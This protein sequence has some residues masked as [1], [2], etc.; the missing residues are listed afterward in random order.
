MRCNHKIIVRSA[1]LAYGYFK[2]VVAWRQSHGRG[3]TRSIDRLLWLIAFLGTSF[4]MSR[5]TTAQL[6]MTHSNEV[7]ARA[8]LHL[9]AKNNFECARWCPL[10]CT[11]R[12]NCDHQ[13]ARHAVLVSIGS[14]D[15]YAFL[16]RQS[17]R[18]RRG[19][20]CETNA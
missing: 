12:T 8:A 3:S 20:N 10:F 18:E 11:K 19:D 1:R 6:R 2:P 13:V 16:R 4:V 17:V 7:R 15:S 9:L 5:I 14:A